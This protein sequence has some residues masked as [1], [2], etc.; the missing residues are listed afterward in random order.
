[1]RKAD[2]AKNHL[3]LD[4]AIA[5]YRAFM[6]KI[7]NAQRVISTAQE[8][9]D[10]AESVLLR[11][12]A[13]WESFVDDHLVD[14]INCDH[15][16]LSDHFDVSIP[17]NPSKDLCHALIVGDGYLDFKSIGELK[18][19]AKKLLPTASN[20]FLAISATHHKRLDE[21][22]RIRNYLSHYSAKSRRSLL[23]VYRSEYKMQ[24]FFE[25]G[26]FLL[27]HHARRLWAYFDAFA[28]VSTDMKATY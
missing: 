19:Y 14:C 1:M 22:Y 17:A 9:R 15:S 8:K 7:I 5:R 4:D 20:P 13:S 16:Q 3:P 21:V 12:C 25:P 10:V 27:A 2:L 11:L 28:G 6:G 26:H 18:G 23:A 24:R